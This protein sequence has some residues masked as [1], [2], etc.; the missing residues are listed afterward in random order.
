MEYWSGGWAGG[1]AVEVGPVEQAATL[2]QVQAT[3]ALRRTAKA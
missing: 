2:R 3:A 1:K